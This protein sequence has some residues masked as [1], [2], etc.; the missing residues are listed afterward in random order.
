MCL[1]LF[2]TMNATFS[3]FFKALKV[4]CLHVFLFLFNNVERPK[5]ISL[6][7]KYFRVPPSSKDLKVAGTLNNFA[8]LSTLLLISH[9]TILFPLLLLT[10]ICHIKLIN[11]YRQH[12]TIKPSI[13][14]SVHVNALKVIW[15]YRSSNIHVPDV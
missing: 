2:S 9:I 8:S 1:L 11:K 15:M 4:L 14:Q 10:S 13:H 12:S 3:T 7:L 5:M 6:R